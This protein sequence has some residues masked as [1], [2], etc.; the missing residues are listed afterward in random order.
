MGLSYLEWN[1]I[2]M[3]IDNLPSATVKLHGIH[4]I[5]PPLLVGAQDICTNYPTCL[6]GGIEWAYN[7]DIIWLIRE[8]KL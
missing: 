2:E 6:I 3:G 4:G 8:K 5:I 7:D 1:G